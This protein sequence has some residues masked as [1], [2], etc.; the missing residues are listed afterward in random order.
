MLAYTPYTAIAEK[1]QAM[2]MLGIG[3]SRMKDFFDIWTP[4]LIISVSTLFADQLTRRS[5]GDGR[6]C[7]HMHGG[8]ALP[9]G[10][11]RREILE[12]L[13]GGIGSRGN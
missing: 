9:M 12:S 11:A 6:Y 3:N 7:I 1:F 8:L 10:R 4:E 13:L 2:V 5:S